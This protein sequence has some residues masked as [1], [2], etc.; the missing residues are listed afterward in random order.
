MSLLLQAMSKPQVTKQFSIH[1]WQLLIQQARRARILGRLYY[2]LRND[3]IKIPERIAWHFESDV[4]ISKQQKLQYIRELAE[5]K[6]FLPNDL[7]F[8]VLKGAAYMLHNLP[9]SIGRL[10]ADIDLLV[11]KESLDK[12]E[13]H[14]KF[15]HWVRSDIDEYDNKYYRLWMHEIP[16]LFHAKKG[17]VLDVHHN[18][19]PLTN[20]DCPDPNSFHYQLINV[21]GIGE[22]S[23]LSNTDL[24]IHSAVH[25]FTE[26]EFDNGLRDLSDLQILLD[27]FTQ[28]NAHFVEILIGR[29]QDLGLEPYVNL[30]LRYCLLIFDSVQIPLVLKTSIL[31]SNSLRLKGLDFCFLRVFNSRHSSCQSKFAF[32]ADFLLY[33]R[34]HYIRMPL[35]LL[36]PHMIKKSSKKLLELF[37]KNERNTQGI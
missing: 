32:L 6:R 30:A 3:G 19:L 9:L 31:E 22:I 12:V 26:S 34:G 16:P 24:F 5:I 33:C 7:S 17:T 27:V 23:T 1:N 11:V 10:C 8:S 15:A 35:S 4:I 13:F 36:L 28:D 29:A 20:K 25:L 37:K 21:E 2:L 14:L 18:I